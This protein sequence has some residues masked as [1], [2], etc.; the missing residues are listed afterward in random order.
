[1]TVREIHRYEFSCDGRRA[2]DGSACLNTRQIEAHDEGHA[3]RLMQLLGW[4][5]NTVAGWGWLCA[6][7]AGHQG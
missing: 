3:A 4:T 6:A 2:A 5:P 7:P 1:M